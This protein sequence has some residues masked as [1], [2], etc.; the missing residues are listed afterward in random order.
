MR[1][2]TSL[3]LVGSF[4]FGISGSFDSHV[5]ALR[6]PDGIALIDAGAGTHTA[7]LL[8]NLWDDLGTDAVKALILTHCHLDHCGG[9]A[10]IRTR[11]GCKVVAPNISRAILEAGDEESIGLQAAQ[12]QGIYPPDLN[13]TPCPVDLGVKDGTKFE[14]AGISFKAVHIRGH[15]EDMFCYLTHFDGH[16]WLFTG[17][18]V[19]YGGVLGV[20]NVQ[21]SG[22]DGYRSDLSKLQGMA[23]EGLFP[24][25]GLVTLRGGQ[26]H[27]DRAIEL[28]KKGFLPPQ[29][30]QGGLVL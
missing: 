17:D 28:S 16:N 24:G 14:A 4:Q 22:M 9:A 8:E 2:T 15:S 20:I 30:G 18:A 12:E 26:K 7:K 5:Y 25:H 23:V 6:G 21:G 19:F 3:A 11:T 13:L 10:E 27:I 1:L 29:V